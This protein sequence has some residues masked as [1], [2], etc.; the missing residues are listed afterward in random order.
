ML[1]ANGINY[2]YKCALQQ[3]AKYPGLPFNN[4]PKVTFGVLFFAVAPINQCAMLLL[5]Y[6]LI[7]LLCYS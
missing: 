4:I 3:E 7:P 2:K 6:F 5:F 1:F